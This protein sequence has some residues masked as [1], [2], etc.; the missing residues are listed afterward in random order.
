MIN[1]IIFD[2]EGVI[3]DT[4]IVW[5]AAQEEF[6]QRR[7]IRYDRA[8]I[9]HLLSGRS[10]A[11]AIGLLKAKYGIEGDVPALAAERMELVRCRLEQGA[12]FIPGFR[13]FFAR[14][15]P[16]YRTA[17]ATAMPADLL[18][19]VDARLGL[20]KLFENR[21]YTLAAVNQRS[22]PNPDIFLYAAGRLAARPAEC[23]VIEDA[24]H[25]VEAARRAGMKCVAI[26]TTYDR[27]LL[28]N[29]DM[30]VDSFTQIDLA[31]L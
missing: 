30:I 6:L 10:Q 8:A 27:S 26:T 12:E 16:Q 21:I 2:A 31:K 9:K 17:V 29:A 11:E 14:I 15:R 22:Q 28:A 3:I 4:E 5:D 20:S 23:L 24:P 19:I 1:A 7:G 13:E 25:G 18:V